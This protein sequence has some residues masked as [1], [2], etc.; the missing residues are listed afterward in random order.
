MDVDYQEARGHG[1]RNAAFTSGDEDAVNL[2]TAALAPHKE[3]EGKPG[4]KVVKKT[5]DAAVKG[6][7]KPSST[8]T[9]LP[10]ADGKPTAFELDSDT[11][12][13]TLLP[14]ARVQRIVKADQDMD[15]ASK[16]A[17]FLLAS[18]AE[19][20]V[21]YLSDLAYTYSRL[22][23]RKAIIYKD[24]Q[25]AIARNPALDFLSD[26]V[27]SS[28]PLSTALQK[29]QGK[30]AD[31][32]LREAGVMNG[33]E[34]ERDEEDNDERGDD[35]D[36]QGEESIRKPKDTNPVL[37]S[38]ST[39]NG[40]GPMKDEDDNKEQDLRADSNTED[41]KPARQNGGLGAIFNEEDDAELPSAEDILNRVRAQKESVSG[42]RL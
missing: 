40:K 9:P 31:N 14:I 37:R 13:T 8:V 34:G 18:A 12:G 28:M 16:E 11:L 33:E 15:L 22:D 25:R 2:A 41:V 36:E 5:Q 10:S 20:F 35:E 1:D 17:I 23:K 39:A 30:L 27:P 24:L 19:Y 3:R 6:K 4:S 7:S 32:L 29:R 26:I 42:T 21:K 38:F